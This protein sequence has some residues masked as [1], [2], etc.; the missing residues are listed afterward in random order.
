MKQKP[1]QFL[2][3]ILLFVTISSEAVVKA[4]ADEINEKISALIVDSIERYN[5]PSIA[6]GIVDR[7]GLAWSRGFGYADLD[8]TI[9]ANEKTR[10]RAGS[11]AKLFTATAVLQLVE[12][13]RVDLDQALSE[14]LTGFGY[15]SRFS[16]PGIITPRHLLTHHSGLPSNINKGFWS[17]EHFSRAVT[18]LRDEYISYPVDFIQ[19]YSNLGYSLLG[20]MIEQV[21]GQG[22]E[23]YMQTQVLTSLGMDETEFSHYT[24]HPFATGYRKGQRNSNLPVRDLP[25]LGLN[26]N[27]EDLARFVSTIIAKGKYQDNRI[28]SR[29]SV[30]SMFRVQNRGVA[31]DFDQLTGIPWMLRRLETR[32][33]DLVAE[34][35]GSMMNYSSY[36]ML[37]PG[38]DFG[39]VMLSNSGEITDLLQYM[40]EEIIYQILDEKRQAPINYYS[41]KPIP[42]MDNNAEPESKRL[43]VAKDGIIELDTGKAEIRADK[44]GNKISLIPLPDGWY[45]IS[46]D[47]QSVTT[48]ITEKTV[49]GYSVMIA[50]NNGETKRVGSLVT[51]DEDPFNW[52]KRFGD[53]EIINPD[54]NF[55]VT[56]VRLLRQDQITYLCYRM[57]KLS[58]KMIF[59]PITPIS[60][61]EAVTQGLGRA[62]GETVLSEVTDNDTRLTYSGFVAKK[63]SDL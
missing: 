55:P 28:L 23:T 52:D 63:I 29:D 51:L 37:V 54:E 46:P 25:A 39:I 19:N 40:S 6:V 60:E 43:F 58:D 15:R 34:H 50:Q 47:A 16:K 36:V 12:N 17:D 49:D 44:Q 1:L 35:S 10:Y 27:V 22:F 59:L 33:R 57:P 4:R 32:S 11:L 26:T 20:A 62:R 31:L 14:Q 38:L 5:I 41:P 53:Y 42:P 13:N 8:K 7:E 9:P 2:I 48:R 45:G 18:L 24:D 21:T 61:N 56:H 3:L 30:E